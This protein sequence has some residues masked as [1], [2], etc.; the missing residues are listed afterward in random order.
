MVEDMMCL[1]NCI[2]SDRVVS[3]INPNTAVIS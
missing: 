3:K 2:D 1:E